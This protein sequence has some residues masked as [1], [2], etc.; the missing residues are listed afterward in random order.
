MNSPAYDD[1][2][3]INDYMYGKASYYGG[4]DGFDGRLMANGDVFDSTNMS[5][6]AHPTLP[7][8][9]KL[10]VTDVST[11]RSIYV[12]VTDRMG[13][14]RNRVIDLSKSAAKILGI[15]GRGLG[16]VSLE[17]VS[18]S[19]FEQNKNTLQIES[20]DDGSPH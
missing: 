3:E 10:K 1:Q 11:G 5:V 9:T 18:E 7:L 8:G 16:S 19:E 14:L 13:R 6:A 20:G 4:N 15:R 12:E 2:S 17:K